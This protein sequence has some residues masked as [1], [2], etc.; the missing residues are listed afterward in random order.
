MAFLGIDFGSSSI[1]TALLDEAGALIASAY[2]K[3]TGIF[4][5]T[6]KALEPLPRESLLRVGVTGNGRAFGHALLGSD[7]APTE[8]L[9]HARAAAAFAP[10]TATVFEI[11]GEDCKLIRLREGRVWD[12]AMNTLCGSGTG[13]FLENLAGRLGLTIEGFGPCALQST[14]TVSVAGKC[15]VFAQSSVV[16][17]LNQGFAIEDIA[18]GIARALI[19]NYFAMLVRTTRLDGPF[20]FQGATALNPALRQAFEEQLGHPVRIPPHPHLMG[21]IG[22]ALFARDQDLPHSQFK[23]WEVISADRI[24]LENLTLSGC[25]NRC[26]VVK[27]RHRDGAVAFFGQRCPDCLG[28]PDQP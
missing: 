12:F 21:A 16:T 5:A 7:A 2:V 20:V 3:N 27:I 26:E 4:A 24:I 19:G 14:K 15:G 22:A 8:I 18:M 17:K 13:S 23:G 28:E 6:L 10:E 11:G 25:A 1:K 9:A